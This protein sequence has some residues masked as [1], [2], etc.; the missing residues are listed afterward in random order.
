MFSWLVNLGAW[1]AVG[2][3]GALLLLGWYV[4]W[5]AATA[6][7]EQGGGAPR[8]A[9]PLSRG[10]ALVPLLAALLPLGLSG[11]LCDLWLFAQWLG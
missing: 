1:G 4:Y 7:F 8:G 10:G 6:L 5:Q 11:A 9:L 3:L 2:F